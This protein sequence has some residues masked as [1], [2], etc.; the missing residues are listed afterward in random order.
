MLSML[1][2][3]AKMALPEVGTSAMP[4]LACVSFS[5]ACTVEVTFNDRKPVVRTGT[6]LRILLP[7]VGALL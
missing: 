4:L 1:S 6:A 2:M 7:S 5:H 3:D